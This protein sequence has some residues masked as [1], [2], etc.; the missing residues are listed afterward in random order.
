[1][2]I[3][4]RELSLN[5]KKLAEKYGSEIL[6][7]NDA[8]QSFIINFG[9]VTGSDTL[10]IDADGDQV[11]RSHRQANEIADGFEFKP[12]EYLKLLTKLGV[13]GQVEFT[14]LIKR[15]ARP[16][17]DS[18]N[19]FRVDQYKELVKARALFTAPGSLKGT[20]ASLS[21]SST[22]IT[23]NDLPATVKGEL[24]QKMIESD[25]ILQIK[26]PV[27]GTTGDL[28]YILVKE[29]REIIARSM[30]AQGFA[31][32]RKNLRSNKNTRGT[33]GK[34]NVFNNH[35][36]QFYATGSWKTNGGGPRIQGP[37]G[38]SGS[39]QFV[40]IHRSGSLQ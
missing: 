3:T 16:L 35:Q 28:S 15:K 40:I 4:D 27:G 36:E 7:L 8:D 10:N 13:L 18:D 37:A 22:H 31:V 30:K 24:D 1:M 19:P 21:G 11:F 23:Y 25:E 26:K 20:K 12:L 32:N 2:A 29:G 38:G 9:Y 17:K 34:F 6:T 33:R 5:Q 39:C 14:K